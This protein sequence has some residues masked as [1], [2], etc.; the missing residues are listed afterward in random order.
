[1]A[2]G[3]DIFVAGVLDTSWTLGEYEAQVEETLRGW[4]EKVRRLWQRDPG[5]WSGADEADWLGWLDIV[6][7]MLACVD[8][9]EE[10][11]QEV[12]EAG[13]ED[14]LLL[15]MGGS[16]L[17]PEVFRMTFGKVSGFPELHVL[18]STVPSQVKRFRDRVNLG[19]TLCVVASKSGTT[20]EPY[21]FLAYFW[22]EIQRVL[23]RAP[24]DRF[25]AITDP[26]S[27]LQA[28][29]EAHEFRRIFEGMP[30]IGGR[31]SA[32]SHFGMVPGAL[33]GVDIREVLGRAKDM[34][35]RCGKDRDENPGVA[36]GA[37]LGTL[38]EAGRD[39]VTLVASPPFWDLGAWLE[40]L[41]AESTGKEGKGLVP[42]EN[43][44]LCEPEGYGEDRV[45]V[46]VRLQDKADPEQDRGV[47]ALKAAGYPVVQIDVPDV[48]SIGAEFFRWEVA[49]VVAGSILG[50]NPFDQPN[51]QE[52]KD[53]TTNL[54]AE[55]EA[56][57][58]LPEAEPVLVSGEIQVF[59]DADNARA[60]GSGGDLGRLLKAHFGRVSTS[61]YVALCA[62]LDRND[63]AQGQLQELR[64]YL[65]DALGVATTVGFG[66]RFLHSTG[67]LHKG[68]ANNGVFL[69]ITADDP[70]DFQIPGKNLSF[71]IM[72]AAQALGDAKALSSNGRRAI[73]VHLGGANLDKL[74]ELVRE[75]L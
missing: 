64:T 3:K 54:T 73:R 11:A 34:V 29:A 9:L 50:I 45:F 7:P 44:P 19:K 43:E 42:V 48:L 8:G 21:A 60:L 49:T 69:Q 18:D 32:L 71:G 22:D 38:A 2:S 65:R 12:A 17:C 20:A 68:G 39:K 30:E 31:F 25:V 4:D 15:G 58:K 5:L 62:Y 23:G 24:G 1:R 47:D 52:S 72:K 51:V 74:L 36:L 33:M 70:D 59:A 46:Y 13:I 27:A 57:G 75:I 55:Y 6:D 41:V 61:D 10:F 16:S 66:P 37:I 56:K 40:Q 67:Q 14:V 35:L 26:G 53:F 28:F 63:E